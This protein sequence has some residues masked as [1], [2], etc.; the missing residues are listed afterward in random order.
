[1]E[2]LLLHICCAPDSTVAFERLKERFIVTGFFY[3]PNI[4]PQTEYDLREAEARMFSTLSGFEYLEG[5]PRHDE[6]LGFAEPFSTEP[7]R[8]ERCRICIA[9]RLEVVAKKTA[10][11][12][13]DVFATTLTVSPHKDVVYIHSTGRSFGEKHGVLY[14]PE[15]LR[16]KDG[17]RRSVELSQEY[18]L[19]RQNYCGC[20]WSMTNVSGLNHSAVKQ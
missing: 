20:R 4:E 8:G 18:G 7:E 9:H 15:T 17:F 19:Y 5:E 1:M 10:E 6:W 14:L 12:G 2:R 3:N 11:L 16:S 13:F